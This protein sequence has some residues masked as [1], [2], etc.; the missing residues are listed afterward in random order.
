MLQTAFVSDDKRLAP[1]A[2]E[3]SL[4]RLHLSESAQLE[5]L[6]SP[7]AECAQLTLRPF[8][9]EATVLRTGALRIAVH[10]TQGSFQMRRRPAPGWISM[11]YGNGV[12]TMMHRGRLCNANDIIVVRGGDAE[13][14]FIGPG[15]L[16]WIDINLERL[17]EAQAGALADAAPAKDVLL[18]SRASSLAS[19]RRYVVALILFHLNRLPEAQIR[20]REDD[21]LD[22]ARLVLRGAR[23][24]PPGS[25]RERAFELVQRVEQFMWEHVEDTLTLE[26]ICKAVGCRSRSLTYYFKTIVG[27]GPMTYLKIR[28]LENAHRRLTECGGSTL[29]IFDVAADFGFWHMGHFGADYKRMFGTTA[30]RTRDVARTG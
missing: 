12:Q 4:V 22:L 26:D 23:P 7:A 24:K 27:V 14:N 20:R 9:A 21:L 15:E 1:S 10:A 2:A 19:L 16:V 11:A 18:T 28:R 5:E 3:E 13:L 8:S 17:P 30:S 29:R 25:M 6:F